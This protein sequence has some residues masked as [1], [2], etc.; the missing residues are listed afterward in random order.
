MEREKRKWWQKKTNWAI[1]L[2]IFNNLMPIAAVV[3]GVGL[4]VV[5]VVNVIAGAFGVYAV[6]DRAGK[7]N[8]AVAAK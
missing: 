6:A 7:A 4:P 1:A 2:G 3:P 5:T 8:E